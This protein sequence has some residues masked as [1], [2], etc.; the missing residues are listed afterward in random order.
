MLPPEAETPAAQT[1]DE[2]APCRPTPDTT[3]EA[4]TPQ[5]AI[6][7]DPAHYFLLLLLIGV[8]VLCYQVIRPYLNPIIMAFILAILLNPVHRRIYKLTGDRANLAAFCSCAFLTIVI[9]LPLFFLSLTLIKQGIESFNNITDWIGAGKYKEIT[10]HPLVG[11]GLSLFDHYLPDIQ[12][13][14]PN[15]EPDTIKID[16][17]LLQVS[18]SFGALL[19][20]K[21][22][23]LFGNLSALIGQFFLM[24][25]AFFFVIRDEDKIYRYL[26]HLIP[27]S[28]T[29][30]KQIISKIQA[31]AKSAFLGTIVTA[32]AQ[33]IAGGLAFWICGLPGLFWGMIMAFASFIPLVGTGL[34]W[35]PAAAFLLISGQWGYGIFLI[36]WSVVIVGS[37]DNFIRPMFMQGGADMS[38]LMIF[39]AILGGIHYFGL[40]GLLYGPLLFGLALVLLYIY[41]LEF[42]TY[43]SDQDG[44]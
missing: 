24:L 43:L 4:R 37:I 29:Q 15:I 3:Q 26:L 30:E 1:T 11:Q 12:K 33:G 20:N 17:M 16:K 19:L 38:T 40:I 34:V 5:S 10:R 14:F 22:G 8:F 9:V 31:V 28:S 42:E 25:F 44:K 6:R 36:I 18:S 7:L 27:L 23:Q 13:V 41:S 39:F 2:K 32:V 35:V 21:G